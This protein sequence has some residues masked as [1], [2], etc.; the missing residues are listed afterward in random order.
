MGLF[1]GLL[2][3]PLAPV[4]GLVWLGEVLL[5]EADRELNNPEAIYRRLEEID[6]ARASGE[7][8]EQECAIAETALMAQLMRAR[9][10]VGPGGPVT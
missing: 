8:S 2:N 3:L 4:R 6:E 1:S 10:R 5:D 7:L 9:A